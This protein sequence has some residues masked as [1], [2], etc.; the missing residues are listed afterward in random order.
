V[1][2][3]EGEHDRIS[4]K[5]VAS[6][7]YSA[8]GTYKMLCQGNTIFTKFRPIWKCVAPLRCK[9]LCWLA[10]KH[11][12]WA[13]VRRRTWAARSTRCLRQL[14]TR[15]GQCRS[16]YYPMPIC[17]RSVAWMPSTS[18]AAEPQLG[19]TLQKLKLTDEDSTTLLS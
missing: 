16:Y 18:R 19:S 15:G 2:R 3:S 7:V 8:R 14:S 17:E 1:L 6:G 9:I 11:R 4:W 10:L 5:G 12:L 13:S